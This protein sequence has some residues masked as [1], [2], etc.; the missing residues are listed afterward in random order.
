MVFNRTGY[1]FHWFSAPRDEVQVI[2]ESDKDPG[3]FP[4]NIT[5]EV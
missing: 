1:H 3:G 4:T 5:C 2:T